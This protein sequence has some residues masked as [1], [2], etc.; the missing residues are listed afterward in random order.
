M[1]QQQKADLWRQLKERGWEPDRHYRDYKEFEL[2]RALGELRVQG[3]EPLSAVDPRDE[4][5]SRLRAQLQQA[6]ENATELAPAPEPTP[7]PQG[8][9]GEEIPGV[10]LNSKPEDEPVKVDENGLVWYQ[11]E[12]PKSATAQPRGRRVLEYVDSGVKTERVQNGEY[13][14]TFEMPGDQQKASRAKITLPSYQVGIYRDPK[15]PFKIHIYNG[16]R[17]YDFFEVCKYYGGADLVPGDIKRVYVSTSLCFD[18]AT[19]N[20]AISSEA[21]RLGILGGM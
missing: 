4:E 11:I 19:T 2:E 8:P 7:I 15:L 10:R 17:G 3:G 18:I 16:Q 5:I 13:V 14:E 6:T 21:R 12:V 20:R 9:L 1:S